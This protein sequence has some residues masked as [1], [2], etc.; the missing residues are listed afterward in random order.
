[1]KAVTP[2]IIEALGKLADDNR[3]QVVA[4]W[5]RSSRDAD[6]DTLTSAKDDATMRQAQGRCQAFGDILKAAEDSKSIIYGK[7]KQA[8]PPQGFQA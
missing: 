2:D 6:L 7:A 4:A 1:V 5:I 3:F 8:A